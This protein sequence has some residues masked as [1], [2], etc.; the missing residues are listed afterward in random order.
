MLYRIHEDETPLG[1]W[2]DG[3]EAERAFF[4]YCD[5][6]PYAEVVLRLGDE[7]ILK[8]AAIAKARGEGAV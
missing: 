1:V 2:V 6:A 3:D 7:V 5:E 8:R 4:Q